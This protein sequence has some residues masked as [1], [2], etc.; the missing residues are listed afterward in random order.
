MKPTANEIR[1]V[2]SR[3]EYEAIDA[4]NQSVLKQF[5]KS[6]A[7]AKYALDFPSEPTPAMDFGTALHA[8]VLM[9]K[10]FEAN[11]VIEPKIDKRTNDGKKAWAAWQLENLGKAAMDN[12]DFQA[13]LEMRDA[14]RDHPTIGPL[15]AE[16]W[17]G[18][19]MAVVWKD[20]QT[21][22]W[23]KAL[24]DRF[25]PS[26]KDDS[27]SIILD[28]KTTAD[29]SEQSFARDVLNYGYDVQAAFYLD[30]MRTIA[31]AQRRFLFAAIEKKKPYA[32]A[33]YELSAET[34]AVGRSKYRE[35]LHAYAACMESGVWPGYQTEIQTIELPRWALENV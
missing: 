5:R 12:E 3:A 34:I 13:I 9:P 18:T 14:L 7:H 2:I 28:L 19:E 15:L 25:I 1:P 10:E 31:E 4:I 26:S 24:L 30:G 29:A 20:E 33:L 23:C 27:V 16:E 8:A 21:G 35:Y 6:A 17:S 32:C 22:V 11:Y